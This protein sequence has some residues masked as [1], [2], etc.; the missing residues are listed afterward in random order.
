MCVCAGVGGGTV[1]AA[2]IPTAA[3]NKHLAQTV[4]PQ[5]LAGIVLPPGATANTGDP[6]VAR[7]LTRFPPAPLSA[8]QAVDVDRFWRVPG[9]PAS[10]Y[11]WL[12]HHRPPGSKQGLTGGLGVRGTR[13]EW[14]VQFN[15]P[16]PAGQL[17]SETLSVAV[18]AA[19]GGG[20]ALR[21]DGQAVWLV[22]RPSWEYV[23]SSVD[24]IAV[25]VNAG[26]QSSRAITLQ[27]SAAIRRI[28]AI[29][30]SLKSLQP[31]VAYSCPEDSGIEV[32]LAFLRRGERIATARADESGC[33]FV[34]LSIERRRGRGL[35]G[36]EGLIVQLL[37][38]RALAI[39]KA[40]QLRGS[41]TLPLRTPA[42]GAAGPSIGASFS[43]RNT[44]S[45]L[46]SMQGYP[47]LTLRTTSGRRLPL[48]IVHF[49]HYTP[50]I[51]TLAPWHETLGFFVS[52]AA[53]CKGPHAATAV[54]RLPRVRHSFVVPVGSRGHP[55]APC[56]SRLQVDGLT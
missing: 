29:V 43:F 9:D 11:R 32:Q 34:T 40:A 49:N 10:V 28:V 51:V 45:A 8:A 2:S 26:R 22:P 33:E 18:A 50:S 13:V 25:T 47:R 12:L 24:A 38:D 52:W 14:I 56:P 4:A 15:Y 53:G 21:G 20:T 3:S 16:A 44:S 19:K 1:V 55:F 42:G 5:R 39:C 6:S 7:R 30:N 35:S 41:A 54:I 31:G 37:R 17:E 46:C 27:S 36:S 48:K 23:P